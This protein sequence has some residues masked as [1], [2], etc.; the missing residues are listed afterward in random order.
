MGTKK[1]TCE[2]CKSAR[3][4]KLNSTLICANREFINVVKKED[5][6]VKNVKYLRVQYEM[7]SNCSYFKKRKLKLK[8]KHSKNWNK[9]SK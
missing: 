4:C 5:P 9:N 2:Y 8:V 7:A 6:N 3:P 1:L